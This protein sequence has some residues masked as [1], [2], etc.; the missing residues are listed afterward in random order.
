MKRTGAAGGVR[1]GG[2]LDLS[3]PRETILPQ[4]GGCGPVC[5]RD[6]TESLLQFRAGP[7]LSILAGEIAGRERALRRACG[8]FLRAKSKRLSVRKQTGRGG[9]VVT[10]LGNQARRCSNGGD[11][12]W[13]RAHASIPIHKLVDK[14]IV[15]AENARRREHAFRVALSASA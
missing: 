9:P 6:W 5:E 15:L 13:P 4:T 8:T 12:P 11:T 7:R 10:L 14:S 2:S 1:R 3:V